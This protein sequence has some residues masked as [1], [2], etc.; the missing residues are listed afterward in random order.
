MFDKALVSFESADAV[1]ENCFRNEMETMER[2]ISRMAF[3]RK[4]YS[5]I[6]GLRR[7]EQKV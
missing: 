1:I 3:C 7:V 6:W 5:A 2:F 4:Q